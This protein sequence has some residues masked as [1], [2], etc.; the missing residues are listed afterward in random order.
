MAQKNRRNTN[1][2]HIWIEFRLRVRKAPE[3]EKAL[4]NPVWCYATT[5]IYGDKI[6][7]KICLW[8]YNV[9]LKM[10]MFFLLPITKKNNFEERS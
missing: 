1:F 7:E 8:T 2:T 10:V 4:Y 3:S 6:Q 5:C 9:E